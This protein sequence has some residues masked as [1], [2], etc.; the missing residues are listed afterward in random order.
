MLPFGPC[1]NTPPYFFTL[2]SA[3]WPQLD[4]QR[5]RWGGVLA[6]VSDVCGEIGW[7][8]GTH[9]QQQAVKEDSEVEPKSGKGGEETNEAKTNR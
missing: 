6:H 7:P 8:C 2:G 3:S 5:E 1:C 9:A 4:D